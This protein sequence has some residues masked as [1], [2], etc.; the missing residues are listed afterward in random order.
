MP[1]PQALI[2]SFAISCSSWLFLG[3]PGVSAVELSAD[4]RGA[5]AGVPR[6]GVAAAD[7]QFEAKMEMTATAK[8]CQSGSLKVSYW[9]EQEVTRG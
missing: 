2:G 4:A 5:D 8:I 3:V 6:M 1:E 9:E 7:R